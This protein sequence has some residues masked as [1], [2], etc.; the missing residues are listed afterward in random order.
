MKSNSIKD[1]RFY[2]KSEE[3]DQKKQNQ[4]QICFGF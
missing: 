4:P 3:P 2:D 1:V